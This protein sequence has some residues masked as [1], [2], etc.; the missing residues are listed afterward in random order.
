MIPYNRLRF[1]FTHGFRFE[2]HLMVNIYQ[3]Y[4]FTIPEEL[5]QVFLFIHESLLLMNYFGYFLSRFID[6]IN[7]SYHLLTNLLFWNLFQISLF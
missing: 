5:E 4:E 6:F 1:T 2:T 7:Y 3:N